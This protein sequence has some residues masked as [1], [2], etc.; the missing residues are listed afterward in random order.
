MHLPV[1][2]QIHICP[3]CKRNILVEVALNGTNHILGMVVICFD[4]LEPH[5]REKAL[6]RYPIAVPIEED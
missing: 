5:M 1:T 6:A 3:K 4:C 2:G